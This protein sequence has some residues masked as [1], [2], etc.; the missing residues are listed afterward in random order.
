MSIQFRSF[1]FVSCLF[2]APLVATRPRV[3]A[4]QVRVVGHFYCNRAVTSCAAGREPTRRQV[5]QPTTSATSAR[6]SWE[7]TSHCEDAVRLSEDFGE[8]TREVKSLDCDDTV[9]TLKGAEYPQRALH[10]AAAQQL[11]HGVLLTATLM[12][13]M[14]T[15]FD[16]GVFLRSATLSIGTSTLVSGKYV[17]Q[18]PRGR[19]YGTTMNAGATRSPSCHSP[20]RSTTWPL[21]E[22]ALDHV[23]RVHEA[24]RG[25]RRGCR[26]S[27]RRGRRS[28]CC[29]G[30]GCGSSSS[31]AGP[32]AARGRAAGGRV[33]RA[34]PCLR[35]RAVAAAFGSWNPPGSRTRSLKSS[36]P[37]TTLRDVV[38]DAV[39]VGGELVPVDRAR[40]P[41][42]AAA[43]RAT[44]A[45]SLRSCSR[46]GCEHAVRAMDH[47]H[48]ILDG[49]E[50]LAAAESTLAAA[51]ARQDQRA[52]RPERGACG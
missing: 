34:R 45:G 33:N 4:E 15:D 26:D 30:R 17:A 32:A 27:D 1:A 13:R 40:A 43:S 3:G 49:D 31:R 47:A 46:A 7:P 11:Q 21:D 28:S 14:I 24:P 5:L 36:N 42:S 41:S 6:L 19:S 38:A 48:R 10:R 22:P 18:L 8:C 9:D 35:E 16:V 29:T 20:T 37:G 12:T 2:L 25:A 23:G 52:L 44:I 39:V 50:L 51:E